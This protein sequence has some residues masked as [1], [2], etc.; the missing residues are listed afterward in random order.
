[1]DT[2]TDLA[3]EYEEWK[4]GYVHSGMRKAAS[5]FVKNMAK[6]L[7]E[8]AIANNLEG[9]LIVGH[10]LGAGT[11]ALTAILMEEYI[12]AQK[13]D[14]KIHA[15][16]FGA[17]PVVS[18]EVAK[19][20]E[21][22]IDTY[23]YGNDIVPKLSYGAFLDFK[24]MLLCASE[25]GDV[26]YFFR[27]PTGEAYKKIM[28][29]LDDCKARIANRTDNINPKVIKIF[30][31]Q[32]YLPGKIY[33]IYVLPTPKNPKHTV[34]ERSNAQMFAEMNIR[35]AM[36]VHHLPSKYEIA[37]NRAFESIILYKAISK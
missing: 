9:I 6:E 10:S 33:H 1:M 30:Y 15:Y 35:P 18:L 27:N 4:G 36:F 34:I 28:A 32:L 7:I 25:N 13:K 29:E 17:P 31:F 2:L 23:I 3:C 16:C 21:Y 22:L 8:Q 12:I 26:S 14:L 19:K 11:A 24:S 20:Y 5:W 37:F